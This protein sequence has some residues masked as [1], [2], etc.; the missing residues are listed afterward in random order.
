MQ[1]TASGARGNSVT[2]YR[3]RLSPSLWVIASAAVVAPMA[4][5]VLSPFDTTLALVA[6]AAIGVCFIWLLVA[7]SPVVEVRD[8]VL[9]A[10]RAHIDVALTGD[11][12]ILTGDEARNARGPGLNPRSWHVIRGGIDGLVIVAITDPDDPAPSWVI[13]TRTP[14]RLAAALRRAQATPRTPGR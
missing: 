11:V 1:K 12:A 5:L 14:D 2:R 6:G 13:S 4:A 8:G 9:T 3:E 7:G 10:G